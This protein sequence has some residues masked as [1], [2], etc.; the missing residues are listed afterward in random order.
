RY[1][2]ISGLFKLLYSDDT[3]D[4][5]YSSFGHT[6]SDE[7]RRSNKLIVMKYA[8]QTLV[9]ADATMVPSPLPE[10]T[11]QYEISEQ[12][13]MDVSPTRIAA[14]TGSYSIRISGTANRDVELQYRFNEGPLA[15]I[16]VHLNSA[17][18][19][20]FFVTKE[21]KRGTYRFVGMRALP[22]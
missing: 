19:T 15:F 1:Y 11:F 16:T 8:N 14:G 21:T 13:K 20:H 22:E 4:V 5:R 9:P 6:I 2:G 12:F 17:G 18:E 10:E 7:L 3:V